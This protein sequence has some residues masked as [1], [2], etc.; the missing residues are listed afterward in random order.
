MVKC[1]EQADG[2]RGRERIRGGKLCLGEMLF[3]M[4]LFPISAYKGFKPFRFTASGKS[5]GPALRLSPVVAGL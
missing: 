4:V 5:T 1:S 3:I 2:E